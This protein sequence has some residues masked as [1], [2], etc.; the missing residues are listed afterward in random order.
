MNDESTSRS[1]RGS[2]QSLQSLRRFPSQT[3]KQTANNAKC[4]ISEAANKFS[5]QLPT[6]KDLIQ[7][8]FPADFSPKEVTKMEDFNQSKNWKGEIKFIKL[9]VK[10]FRV[11]TSLHSRVQTKRLRSWFLPHWYWDTRLWVYILPGQGDCATQTQE[12][13]LGPLPRQHQAGWGQHEHWAA[14]S[15]AAG[16]DKWWVLQ[17]WLWC[18]G[19]LLQHFYRGESWGSKPLRNVTCSKPITQGHILH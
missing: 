10:C 14:Q 17:F 4:R 11:G 6:H 13:W 3:L 2:T 18:Y 9:C 7:K 1:R 12:M 16:H 19:E 15:V 8:L 5:L